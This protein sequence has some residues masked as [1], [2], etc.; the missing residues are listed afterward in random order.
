[1]TG[2][3]GKVAAVTGAGS[4]IGQALAVELARA[5]ARLAISDVDAEGLADTESRVVGLGA[6]C[7]TDRLD[8]TER[9]AVL[10]YADAVNVFA[11]W[12]DLDPATRQELMGGAAARV[13]RWP[14]PANSDKEGRNP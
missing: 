7:K 9:Q 8:V 5:G 13:F 6:Q 12:P 11:Y 2:F 10:T 3:S 1:M 14:L 4:G